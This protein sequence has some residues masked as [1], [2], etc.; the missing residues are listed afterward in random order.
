MR[1]VFIILSLLIFVF[2]PCNAEN[3]FENYTASN[4]RNIFIYHIPDDEGEVQNNGTVNESETEIPQDIISDDVTADTSGVIHE[5]ELDDY[6]YDDVGDMYSF[7]LKGYAEYNE[8][9]EDA[10]SLDI[11]EN[12]LPVLNIR[13][14][15]SVGEKYFSG[16]KQSPSLIN[17]IYTKYNGTEY[18]IA[19]VSAVASRSVGG[20]SAGTTY[21]QGIDYGELEQSS[22]IFTKYQYKNFALSTSYAKTVNSTNNNYNDNFYIIPELRLSQYLTL[23]NIFSADTAKRR[24]KAEVVLSL[25]P[26]GNK[27]TD[28]MRF[29]VGASETYD[30]ENNL[31][32]GQFRFSTN[33]KF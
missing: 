29:E 2:L 11:P 1:R 9:D 15:V 17:N 18:S 33:F 24:K 22:G 7:V 12:E 5:E 13:Q 32:K 31:L 28:R 4:G 16:L 8:G 14:P 26:F 30:D 27:D 6:D 25:N 20:F 23:K 10:V 3:V 19:P 21:S